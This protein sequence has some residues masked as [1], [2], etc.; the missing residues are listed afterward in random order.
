MFNNVNEVCGEENRIYLFYEIYYDPM[1]L[2]SAFSIDLA[3]TYDDIQMF[4]T[5][6]LTQYFGGVFHNPLA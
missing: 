5:A 2:L 6:S 3:V 4:S 1:L